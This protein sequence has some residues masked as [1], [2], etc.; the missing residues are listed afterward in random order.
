MELLEWRRDQAG[1]AAR[2]WARFRRAAVERSEELTIAVPERYGHLLVDDLDPLLPALL[3]PCMQA[4]E[5][6]VLPGEV[7][8][9]LLAGAERAQQILHSWYPELAVVDIQARARSQGHRSPASG[10]ATF[11]S[12]GVDSF[13][14]A[15]GCLDGTIQ[16]PPLSH[17]LYIRAFGLPVEQGKDV[18][19]T[20]SGMEAIG[21]EL[22]LELVP[23]T[24]DLT[25]R[26]PLKWDAHYHGAALASVAL[27]LSGGIGRVLV[28]ASFFYADLVPWGSHPL[29]D[30]LWSTEWLEL[31]HVGGEARRC[32]KL[33]AL[34]RNPLALRTLNVCLAHGNRGGP[35][36]CGRCTKCVRTMV[37]LDLLGL[38][39][40]TPRFPGRL[41][42]GFTDVLARDKPECRQELLWVARKLGTRPE[43]TSVLERLERRLRRR[44][45]LRAW[46]ESFAVLR[47]LVGR[48][49]TLRRAR[50]AGPS[51]LRS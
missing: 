43:L 48:I 2:L 41:P 14:T 15:L 39:G 8:P 40:R 22:G 9:R 4:G 44:Q 5:A 36:N 26:F 38:L 20:Q 23:V 33:Q 29:L 37:N 46:M 13:Y 45:A 17:L 12:G 34:A 32:D 18:V 49:D 6:L 28:S 19:H 27:A 50:R 3:V 16:G 30:P 21:R 25:S 10:C 42:A 51:A 31:R 1:G 35:D 11:F 7:S 47:P 24:T